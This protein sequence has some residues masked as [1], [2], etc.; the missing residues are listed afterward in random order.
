MG[1]VVFYDYECFGSR[2]EEVQK[3]LNE[4]ES[5]GLAKLIQFN[6]LSFL[7]GISVI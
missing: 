1:V 7:D 3:I 5:L 2:L 6:W 4:I